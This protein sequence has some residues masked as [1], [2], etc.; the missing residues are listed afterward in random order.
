[1]FLTSACEPHNLAAVAGHATR[2]TAGLS[3]G[4]VHASADAYPDE[5]GLPYAYPDEE[6]DLPSNQAC[7]T[8]QSCAYFISL[9]CTRNLHLQSSA[10]TCPELPT[11]LACLH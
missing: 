4:D 9:H 3:E 11:L 1:M 2:G 5:E 6:E 7:L 8:G 10:C